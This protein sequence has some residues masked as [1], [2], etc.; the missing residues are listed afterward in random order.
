[1][2]DKLQAIV[3]KAIFKKF[4]VLPDHIYGPGDIG[5][6]TKFSDL[7]DDSI[8]MLELIM[9]LEELIP[10]VMIDDDAIDDFQTVGDIYR[11]YESKGVSLK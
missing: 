3:N 10:S 4:G 9:E 7:R 6:G 11:Y 5:V 1:M 2:S 8:D